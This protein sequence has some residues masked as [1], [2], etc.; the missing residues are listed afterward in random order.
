MR[1]TVG[2]ET[3]TDELELEPEPTRPNDQLHPLDP[4]SLAFGIIF[5]LA[6]ALFLFG[7]VSAAD[8]SPTWGFAALFGAIGLLLLAVGL[9]RHN[10]DRSPSR[11]LL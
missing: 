11:E 3:V 6:G 8:L 9:R 4:I 7:D 5:T 1:E 10:R 2:E